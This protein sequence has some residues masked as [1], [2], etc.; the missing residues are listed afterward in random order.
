MLAGR[1]GAAVGAAGGDNAVFN[2]KCGV[3]ADGHAGGAPAEPEAVS[4]EADG[5]PVNGVDAGAFRVNAADG[6][7]I[8]YDAGVLGLFVGY[9]A[10]EEAA[11][12]GEV[13]AVFSVL[14]VYG[15][16]HVRLRHKGVHIHR[17][18]L[19][20]LVKTVYV[21]KLLDGVKHIR[22][23]HGRVNRYAFYYFSHVCQSFRV[24]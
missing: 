18:A 11:G 22:L 1:A 6:G 5:G 23:P 14:Y 3:A 16:L 19:G 21:D 10:A 20:Y 15:G 2:D 17:G 7:G 12:G 24:I 9:L 8:G 13:R 4:G